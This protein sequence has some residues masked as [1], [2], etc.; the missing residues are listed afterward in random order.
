VKLTLFSLKIGDQI[1]A[2]V[3]EV[4]DAREIIF[5][6]DGDLLRVVNDTGRAF[7]AGEEAV[8]YVSGINPLQFRFTEKTKSARRFG[9]F[10]V[11]V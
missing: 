5:S 10:D 1:L 4:L 9:R 6:F 2:Q 11:T 8:L 7:K 3:H